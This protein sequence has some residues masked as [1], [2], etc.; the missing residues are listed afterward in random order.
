MED[1]ASAPLPNEAQDPN[2]RA[3]VMGRKQ[4]NQEAF[5]AAY[6]TSFGNVTKSAAAAN[7]N[8]WTH[9]EWL[10]T[11]PDYAAAFEQSREL[12]R[13]ARKSA[14]IER[15][16]E[17]TLEPRT[18]AGERVMVRVFS[19]RLAERFLEADFPEEFSR[20]AQHRL[21]DKDGK[22]RELIPLA[23]ID[24]LIREAKAREKEGNA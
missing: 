7:L 9:Y 21:V 18:V 6:E 5:L 8:P 3:R 20:H 2:T 12:A 4:F 19:D 11:D 22:D 10:K 24:D 17:G 13:Q 15:A 23:A 14:A 16:F 1:D